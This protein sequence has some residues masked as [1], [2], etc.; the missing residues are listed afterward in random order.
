MLIAPQGS[1]ECLHPS[2][3]PSPS[4]TFKDGSNNGWGTNTTILL[5][6]VDNHVS[7]PL[8][9][10][11]DDTGLPST[12]THFSHDFANQIPVSRGKRSVCFMNELPYFKTGY[13]KQVASPSVLLASFKRR[14]HK[15]PGRFKCPKEG[16]GSDFTR[17]N[18]LDS[19]LIMC[20]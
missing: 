10:M 14:S 3:G 5:P 16:C 7:Q 15:K 11:Q 13:K 1:L 18:N 12:G 8:L 17:K 9:P 19:G 6:E 4:T 2:D 20:L